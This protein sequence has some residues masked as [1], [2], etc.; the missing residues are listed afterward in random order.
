MLSEC[1]PE[2]PWEKIAKGITAAGLQMS[3][4]LSDKERQ[5]LLPDFFDLND[6][7]AAGPAINPGTVQ[8][9]LTEL[10]DRGKIYDV[11][12]LHKLGW[13]VHAPCRISKVFVDGD[14][15]RFTLDGWGDKAYFVLISGV[16]KEPREVKVVK[17]HRTEHSAFYEPKIHSESSCLIMGLQGKSEINITY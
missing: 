6:Q 12:K 1:D 8:A 3:W 9:H 4:S 13:F 7:I 15:I 10:Y 11:R 2:G 5:G 16:E 14:T 17:V